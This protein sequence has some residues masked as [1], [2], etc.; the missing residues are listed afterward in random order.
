LA[1]Q[2]ITANDKNEN[3]TNS[4]TTALHEAVGCINSILVRLL[5]TRGDDANAKNR[6]GE[7][8]LHLAARYGH[9]DAVQLLLDYRAN[10][11]IQSQH[12]S[13]R[14]IK[15]LLLEYQDWTSLHESAAEGHGEVVSIL[16]ANG[17]K[18]NLKT[19]IGRSALEEAE[20]SSHVE[21]ARLLSMHSSSGDSYA[22]V[23]R[24]D[25]LIMPTA[26]SST[27]DPIEGPPCPLQLFQLRSSSE[28]RLCETCVSLEIG[29][30]KELARSD[31]DCLT[32]SGISSLVKSAVNGCPM[33]QL[34]LDCLQVDAKK[35]VPNGALI[36]LR[37]GK[38]WSTRPPGAAGFI[39]GAAFGDDEVWGQDTRHC[40]EIGVEDEQHTD[41]KSL[42]LGRMRLLSIRG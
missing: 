16:L 40:L 36:K 14:S 42:L 35:P 8:P 31:H 1:A 37:S 39:F 29:S 4:Q 5:L 15:N 22:T 17:A 12:R 28:P 25:G 24:R 41:D 11:D 20:L 38:T 2:L 23:R 6:F 34:I 32:F 26:T 19:K 27:T 30:L 9:V 3:E 7:T 10:V 33:C 18:A 13:T 21:V